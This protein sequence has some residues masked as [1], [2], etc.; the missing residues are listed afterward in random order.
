MPDVDMGVLMR[1]LHTSD[2]HLGRTLYGRKRYDEFAAFLSWLTDLIKIRQVDILLL[3]GDVFDN[4]TPGNRAQELYYGFLAGLAGTGCRHVVIIA[5]NHDSPTF[6][7]APQTLLKA[8]HIHVIG[9]AREK[10][11]DECLVLK[12]SQ[13]QPEA[14]ICAV[15]YLH[16]RDI[17]TVEA[18]ETQADKDRKMIAGIREHYAAVCAVAESQRQ[19]LGC[20]VPIIALG[21]LFAAGGQTVEG[22][23][24]RELYVGSLAHVGTDIFPAAID[25]LAL[26]H[27]HVP[28]RLN[29]ADH[30]RYSGSPLPM[31]YGEAR[32]EKQVVL[33]DFAGYHPSV[34]E[35]AV[36]CF[37]QLERIS[38]PLEAIMNRLDHL[39]AEQSAAWIEIEYTGED[40]IS[41]LREQI[42]ERIAGTALEVRRIKNKRIVDRVI[43]RSCAEETLDD[44][45]VRDV[46]GRCLDSHQVSDAERADLQPLYDT[47]IAELQQGGQNA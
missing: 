37:Q 26:G 45:D 25:Y 15:P 38:G 16:D 29:G 14:I 28:Q 44:L 11:A 30:L 43:A 20:A 6:L 47:V 2:W 23:G 33:V 39:K 3:A 42:D 40:I 21:H 4:S 35:Q 41:D 19:A 13:G 12:D 1:I 31:G 10:P 17:R 9:A 18:D 24:V 46:F 32:Q 7:D 8:L 34:S 27:L 5:G 36:P 22:D